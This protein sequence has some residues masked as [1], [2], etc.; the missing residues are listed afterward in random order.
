MN[1]WY[2]TDIIHTP[3]PDMPRK[4]ISITICAVMTILFCA[5]KLDLSGYITFWVSFF[6]GFCLS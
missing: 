3:P 2:T 4:T 1:P 5:G 6:I